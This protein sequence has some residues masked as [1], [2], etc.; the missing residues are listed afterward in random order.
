MATPS[1]SVAF[2]GEESASNN[3]SK[4]IDSRTGLGVM[5]YGMAV[6]LRAKLKSDLTMYICDVSEQ[7][8]ERFQSEM[9]GKGPISV[10]KNGYDAVQSAVVRPFCLKALAEVADPIVVRRIRSFPCFLLERSS[11]TFI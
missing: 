5:G 1:S 3:S 9:A 11:R 4:C 6:N 8:L 10:V 2:I 7:A